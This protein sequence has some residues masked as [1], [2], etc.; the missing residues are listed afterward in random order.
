MNNVVHLEQLL[1]DLFH[2]AWLHL[3]LWAENFHH[4]LHNISNMQVRNLPDGPLTDSFLWNHALSKSRA[5]APQHCAPR[6][7]PRRVSGRMSEHLHSFF[8]ELQQLS[9]DSLLH[10]TLLHTLLWHALHDFPACVPETE[11]LTPLQ[12]FPP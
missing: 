7:V 12:V 5:L 10:V 11:A 8:H 4:F 1:H 9:V 3:L 6:Y 2:G